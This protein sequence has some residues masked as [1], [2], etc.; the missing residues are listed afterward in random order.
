[1]ILNCFEF[2]TEQEQSLDLSLLYS[3]L[4][5]QRTTED[6]EAPGVK[7][8]QL[9]IIQLSLLLPVIVLLLCW[10]YFPARLRCASQ[11][12]RGE[13]ERAE[14]P[15]SYSNADLFSLGVS[16]ADHLHPPPDYLDLSLTSCRSCSALT[17][18]VA[19]VRTSHP[20]RAFLRQ[21]SSLSVSGNDSRIYYDNH[22]VKGLISRFQSAI[23]QQLT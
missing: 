5:T 7:I 21:D 11:S 23:S 13:T 6:S 15:P 9:V 16:V 19:P 14:L 18:L 3:V 4:A 10:R 12:D 8:W 1:M 2:R 20:S 22:I 17:Q